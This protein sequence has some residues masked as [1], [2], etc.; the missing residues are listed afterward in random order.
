MS[1]HDPGETF[2]GVSVGTDPFH[3]LGLPRKAASETEVLQAL[4]ARMSAIAG[5]PRSQTPEANEIRLALHAAAAQLLDPKLQ[6]LLLQRSGEASQPQEPPPQTVE[7]PR[8][9]ATNHVPMESA[10]PYVHPLT[11]DVLLVVAANG[12]WNAAAMRRLAMLAHA[13]LTS[14]CTPHPTWLPG[15]SS[16]P[17][18]YAYQTL[19]WARRSATRCWCTW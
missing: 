13:K 19:P 14:R 9:E 8:P 6:E 12:G 2:F 17:P 7:P 15:A 10:E 4:G 16:G 1:A 11:H 18:S 5:H 3:L